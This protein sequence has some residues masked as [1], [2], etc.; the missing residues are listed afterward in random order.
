MNSIAAENTS[1]AKKSATALPS[2][3][4][5]Y[6]ATLSAPELIDLMRRDEDRV[7]RN[8]IDACAQR[9]DAML[10]AFEPLLQDID[11]YWNE[12]VAHGDW[13]LHTDR[14]STRL[15]SSHRT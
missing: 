3:D 2:Y 8:V 1:I 13:W 12:E 11:R 7:P 5:T 9:G 15:N 6:L 10:D 4:N 14:K